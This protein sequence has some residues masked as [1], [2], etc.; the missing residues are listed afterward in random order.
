MELEDL[1]GH[2]V[3]L[4]FK[5]VVH[6][7]ASGWVH[8][9]LEGAELMEVLDPDLLQQILDAFRSVVF[10]NSGDH[11]GVALIIR[12]HELVKEAQE[13]LPH[14]E[15]DEHCFVKLGVVVSVAGADG[16]ELIEVAQRVS[17]LQKNDQTHP[18]Q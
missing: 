7:S 14:W 9:P 12:H 17:V 16:L 6:D 4:K 11:G 8:I 3:A 18:T 5:Q 15:I 1:N 2:T 13:I 10:K